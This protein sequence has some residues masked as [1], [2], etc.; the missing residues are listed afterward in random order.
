VDRERPDLS[1]LV[2]GTGPSHPSGHVLAAVALW[3]LLPPLVSTLVRSRAVWW[4]S[5]L[6]SGVLIAGIAASR[7]YLGVHWFADVVQGALLGAVYLSALE[8]LFAHHHRHRQCALDRRPFSSWRDRGPQSPQDVAAFA[9]ARC[10]QR[11][12]SSGKACHVPPMRGV[13]LG[14]MMTAQPTSVV[15]LGTTR[16]TMGGCR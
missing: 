15:S 16:E 5:V 11:T 6:A 1:R 3:G 4:L 7:V 12:R 10:D 9:G 14:P 13:T 2:D 8:L